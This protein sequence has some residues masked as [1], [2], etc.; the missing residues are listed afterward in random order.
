MDPS[1]PKMLTKL[2]L[3]PPFRQSDHLLEPVLW[4]QWDARTRPGWLHLTEGQA[5][6]LLDAMSLVIESLEG[7]AAA[8]TSR[9]WRARHGS[10][11]LTP[12]IGGQ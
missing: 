6:P 10:R 9:A 7:L 12:S 5:P 1:L 3:P 4:Q 8:A 2:A 11:W